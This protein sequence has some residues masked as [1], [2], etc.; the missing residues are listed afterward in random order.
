MVLLNCK[1]NHEYLIVLSH[2]KMYGDYFCRISLCMFSEKNKI[3]Q[4]L[5][6]VALLGCKCVR[7]CEKIIDIILSLIAMKQL[8]FKR[9]RSFSASLTIF[10]L[11]LIKRVFARN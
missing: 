6:Q 11:S 7:T 3:S 1:H 2:D 8:Y 4:D 10:C 9:S 5:V